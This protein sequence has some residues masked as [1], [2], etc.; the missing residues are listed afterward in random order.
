M[1]QLSVDGAVTAAAAPAPALSNSEQHQQPVVVSPDDHCTNVYVANLPPTADAPKIREL[2]SSVGNVL[3]VKVLLDIATGVSR[4]IAFVMFDDLATARKACVLKNKVV[5][6]GSVLQVRLAERSNMHS[7]PDT[8]I[9]SCI[10]YIRNVPGNVHKEQVRKMCETTFGPVVDVVPHPQS[11]E[12]GGPSPFNMVFVTFDSMSDACRCV[13][14]IDGKAPFPLS[15]PSHPFTMAKMIKDIGGEMRKSILLRRR[16][17][18]TPQQSPQQQSIPKAHSTHTTPQYMAISPNGMP[19]MS[20]G[21]TPPQSPPN[22][23]LTPQRRDLQPPP[24]V[25]PV[26]YAPQQPMYAYQQGPNGQPVLVQ[27]APSAMQPAPQQFALDS[28][29][30]SVFIAPPQPIQPTAVDGAPQQQQQHVMFSTAGFPQ[31]VQP[32]T[33]LAAPQGLQQYPFQHQLPQQF[34]AQAQQPFVILNSFG[35]PQYFIPGQM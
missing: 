27:I 26:I 2:F 18:E 1:E 11:C 34:A 16:G 35:Q 32:Q 10:V 21:S 29:R 15:H 6:D 33:V 31:F 25:Q 17:S 20:N 12:L 30:Q 3:H 9:R 24:Q 23:T 7:S 13:E 8:H 4:G 19:L 14:G 5:L 22:S 28:Q